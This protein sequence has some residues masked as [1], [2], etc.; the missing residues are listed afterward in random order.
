MPSRRLT[1]GG[2]ASRAGSA[3][4]KPRERLRS[5]HARANIGQPFDHL[6][7]R[8]TMTAPLSPAGPL[9]GVRVLDLS[10]MIAAPFAAMSLGELGADVVKVERAGAGDDT[11]FFGPFDESGE[12]PYFW[13][14]NR[15]KAGIA[16]DLSSDEGRQVV[17]R[18]ALEWAD[19]VI[20]NFKGGTLERWGLGLD[21]LRA[22]KPSLV[23]ASVRGYPLGDD[24]PGY[25][26]ILQAGAGL[27]SI[28]GEPDGD[29][30]RVGLPV[31]DLFA[32]HYL[33]S[34]ILAALLERAR[35]GR[36]QHVSV[37][38]YE[39]QVSMLAHAGLHY[40]AL[41]HQTPRV[42]NGN[43]SAGP[44]DVYPTKT[45][46]VAVCCGSQ[47]QFTGFCRELGR[48][49]LLEDPRFGS[50]SARVA[51]KSDLDAIVVAEFAALP[52]EAV[53]AKLEAAGVPSGPVRT[54]PEVFDDEPAT[55]PMKHVLPTDGGGQQPA[56]GL[57]WVFSDTPVG[58]RSAA[59]RLGQQS[60]EILA[61]LTDGAV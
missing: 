15:N 51:H 13:A 29:P 8:L 52:A 19:V 50:N 38:L 58:P 2:E 12:S 24:R 60:E 47:H 35:S 10:R 18:L 41:G 37:S 6:Q 46:P 11:R 26:F 25:D 16:L 59:P 23:T 44:Y 49:D 5:A 32:G 22:E 1:S 31:V 53:L 33:T 42:G 39:A 20:E 17:R 27:M 28:T 43:S 55:Q 7:E 36:G 54:L 48:E 21:D 30:V 3:R 4:A 14:Y 61:L 34:G 56:I 40:L 57:P 45:D 9:S